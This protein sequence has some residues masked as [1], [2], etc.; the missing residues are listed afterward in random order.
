MVL[1]PS[2][3]IDKSSGKPQESPSVSH[4][5][6]GAKQSPLDLTCW[7]GQ[8]WWGPLSPGRPCKLLFRASVTK[9]LELL[10]VHLYIP[11]NWTVLYIHLERGE[12]SEVLPLVPHHHH[13]AHNLQV[14]WLDIFFIVCVCICFLVSIGIVKMI[15][16]LRQL[17]LNLFLDV[18]WSHVLSTS[19]D[20]DLLDPYNH[21]QF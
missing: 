21:C 10:L 5:S 8:G 7:L 6:S 11:S 14:V 18:C 3:S 12:T 1:F 17:W 20:D 9:M 4:P 16:H 13:V 19:R 2:T 15:F